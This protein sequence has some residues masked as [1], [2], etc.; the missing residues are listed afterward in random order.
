MLGPRE[1][2]TAIADVLSAHLP[3]EV[4]RLAVELGVAVPAL[5]D[6]AGEGAG[7]DSTAGVDGALELD[8]QP[9]LVAATQLSAL[10]VG[11]DD[12]P[13][14]LVV[15]QNLRSLRRVQVTDSGQY[16]YVARYPVRIFTWARGDGYHFTAAVR[17]R[18]I[19]AVR[20]TLLRRQ[21]LEDAGHALELDETT[22]S[23][24]YSDVGVDDVLKATVAA[25]YADTEWVVS[26]LLTPLAGP[27]GQVDT[28]DTRGQV[29][30]HPAL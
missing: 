16:V 8:A 10:D 20:E 24:S 25:A 30:P 21:H 3:A 18:L 17:D 5:P 12:W 9:R 14:V 28:L 19:L 29:L 15:P 13:F 27:L 22:W 4:D 23:E 1:V 11:Y 7:G 6:Q 26:S 2:A